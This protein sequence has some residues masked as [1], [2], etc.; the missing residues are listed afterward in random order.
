[1]PHSLVLSDLEFQEITRDRTVCIWLPRASVKPR[2][3]GAA[4]A[5]LAPKNTHRSDNTTRFNIDIRLR[6]E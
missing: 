5:S 2:P 3:L 1:M 6:A 4:R